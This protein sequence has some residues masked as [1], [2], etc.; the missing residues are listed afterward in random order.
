MVAPEYFE[1]AKDA[2]RY[3]RRFG[4]AGD[5]ARTGLGFRELAVD[6]AGAFWVHRNCALI[7]ECLKNGFE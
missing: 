7:F 2:C 4:L 6:G 1:G 5:H 3:H